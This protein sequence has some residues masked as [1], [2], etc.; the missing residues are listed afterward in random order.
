MRMPE[1]RPSRTPFASRGSLDD[2]HFRKRSYRA[3]AAYAEAKL[4]D[5]LYA[6]ELAER[7]KDVGVSVFS[8][9]PGW[10]R[11][12]F[13]RGGNLLMRA[14]FSI[15]RPL[16]R[17][18][19]DSNEDS[20]QTSLHCMLSDDAP[21]HS[22]AYFSQSSVLYRDSECK[23]GGWPLESPNPNATDMQTALELVEVSRQL[24]GLDR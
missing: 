16:T 12:N 1:V 5:V 2:L 11:S 13:G 20:A 24:V 8:V 4:A 23:K 10:A 6:K 3:F 18:L 15:M 14:V 7:L 22:G 19:S 9:H 21:N 17:A